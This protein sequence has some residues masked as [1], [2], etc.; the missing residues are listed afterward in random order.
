MTHLPDPA[1]FPGKV[2]K[3]V[4][5]FHVKE[6]HARLAQVKRKIVDQNA[7]AFLVTHPSDI[8]YL[9]GYTA[10]SAY[11]AQ[12]L[13]I[14]S[15]EE[16][17]LLFLRRQDGPAGMH[18]TFMKNERIIPYPERYIGDYK[19]NGFDF[20]LQDLIK[21]KIKRLGVQFDAMTAS[22][23]GKLQ[24]HYAAVELVDLS[25]VIIWQRLIKSPAEIAIMQQAAK[26]TDQTMQRAVLAFTRCTRECDVA[27]EIAAAQ[28]SG[29]RDLPGDV[30]DPVL[31]PGGLQSGTSHINWTENAIVTGTHYN[32]EL[33][34]ARHRYVVPIMRTVS[35]GKPA[36]KLANLY[37]YMIEA[38]N[39]T[40]EKIKPG[41]TCGEVAQ[42]YVNHLFK[43]G[44]LKDSRC[45]YPIGINWLE[46]SCSLRVDDPT[47][48]QENM[49]FHL[50]LGTWL[51]EDFGAII[52]ES[53]FVTE[54]GCQVFGQFPR[55]LV[56]LS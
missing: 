30:C 4:L 56:V 46:A 51:E 49:A 33:A 54:N 5:P 10:Q 22:T 37:P 20:I 25:A 11:V 15:S 31:M 8:T 9:S 36:K 6:Y 13:V 32:V 34:G 44:H 17:P 43:A 26:I 35:I 55:E 38:C 41:V 40:L 52:S 18:T 2:A 27:A 42:V 14:L 47:V 45:G 21:R 50:M 12:G 3:R 48:L 24:A 39:K 28:C 19:V 16:E 29:T 7:E 1:A 23:L 53:F